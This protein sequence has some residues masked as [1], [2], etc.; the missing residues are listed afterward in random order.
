MKGFIVVLVLLALAIT[1]SYINATEIYDPISPAGPSMTLP[2]NHDYLIFEQNSMKHFGIVYGGTVL[3]VGKKN[4]GWVYFSLE[5]LVDNH[6]AKL[7]D[8]TT[9]VQ[10]I[11][12]NTVEIKGKI[13]MGTGKKKALPKVEVPKS[14]QGF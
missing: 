8:D 6:V 3:T 4:N 10:N 1:P 7:F 14:Y 13:Y 5:C 2:A 11:G 12:M 9:K